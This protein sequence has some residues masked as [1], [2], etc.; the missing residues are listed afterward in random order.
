MWS[1]SLLPLEFYWKLLIF[2]FFYF[3]VVVLGF[4]LR[5]S[6][7]RGRKTF[8]YLVV[9]SLISPASIT[10][11]ILLCLFHHLSPHFLLLL[12][13]LKLIRVR[14]ISWNTKPKYHHIIAN[15]T[16][17][18]QVSLKTVHVQI[19]PIILE[20]SFYTRFIQMS[21]QELLTN[22]IYVS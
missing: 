18:C 13:I 6:Y 14:D 20:M 12:R 17:N 11:N 7:L 10:V 9:F 1:F 5:A 2:L 21:I 3:L 19:S 15:K 4:E 22:Y 8:Y 16:N